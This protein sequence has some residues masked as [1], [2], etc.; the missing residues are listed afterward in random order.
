LDLANQRSIV[1]RTAKTVNVA[2]SLT[3]DPFSATVGLR[4]EKVGEKVA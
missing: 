2:E 1:G 4:R 3:F